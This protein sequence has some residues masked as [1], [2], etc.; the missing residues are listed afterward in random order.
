MRTV[1]AAPQAVAK[2]TKLYNLN[3]PWNCELGGGGGPAR[4]GEA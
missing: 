1:Q 3:A 2:P 4:N